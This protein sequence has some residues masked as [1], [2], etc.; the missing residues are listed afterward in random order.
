MKKCLQLTAAFCAILTILAPV[1]LFAQPRPT[2]IRVERWWTTQEWG[3]EGRKYVFEYPAENQTIET[4]YGTTETP[5][6]WSPLTRT[7]T[8]FDAHGNKTEELHVAFYG[9][10]DTEYEV[11]HMVY[12]NIY[13]SGRLAEVKKTPKTMA[14]M[15]IWMFKDVYVYESGKLV[16]IAHQIFNALTDSYSDHERTV[17][18]YNGDVIDYFTTVE[19][20]DEE[21]SEWQFSGESEK[22][23]HQYSGGRLATE[24]IQKWNEEEEGWE[25]GEFHEYTY[26]ADGSVRIKLIKS[27]E[28]W[29]TPPQ[30]ENM[31]R[32]IYSYGTT[33]VNDKDVLLPS[34]FALSNYPNPFNPSTTISFQIPEQAVVSLDVF[35]TR[36]RK[37]RSL[38]SNENRR[39]GAYFARW[40][41]MNDKG[42]IMPSGVY[43]YRLSAPGMIIS[44]QCILLK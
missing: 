34:D 12:E 11:F 15:G 41:G 19:Q 38:I 17:Y 33:S 22:H 16:R 3:E 5:G 20:W 26:N 42:S 27:W 35:D 29:L 25:E 21:S 31:E 4:Q 37:I 6:E 14:E 13:Q 10:D 18:H 36:G 40:D 28:D 1:V 39:A 43:I 23:I 8:T 44:R 24:E 9:D 30:Y 7:T 2:E 32:W